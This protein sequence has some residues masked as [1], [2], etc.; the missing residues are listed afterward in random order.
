LKVGESISDPPVFKMLFK[1]YQEISIRFNPLLAQAGKPVP[2][3][4]FADNLRSFIPFRRHPGLVLL[5][6]LGWSST[7]QETKG[8]I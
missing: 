6:N 1:E 7:R 3:L 8:G 4:P 5:T 2:P